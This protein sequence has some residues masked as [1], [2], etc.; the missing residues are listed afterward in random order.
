MYFIFKNNDEACFV[1]RLMIFGKMHSLIYIMEHLEITLIENE[2]R[3]Q[4]W[5]L[6]KVFMFNFVFAHILTLFLVSMA[7]INEEDNWLV[8]RGLVEA[9]WSEKYIWGYYWA[10][11]IMLTV[12]FGD[13]IP[14]NS[15]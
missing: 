8:S 13:I 7:R 1:F 15:S 14:R 5:S 3:E 6:I 12:G 10:T 4:I 2:Y 9:E 11:T